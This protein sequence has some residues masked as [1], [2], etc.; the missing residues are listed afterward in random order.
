MDPA[1]QGSREVD[2]PDPPRLPEALRRLGPG[3]LLVNEFFLSIQGESTRAGRPCFFI[4]L[5]GCHIRCS[6][7][8]TPYAFHDGGVVTAEG[9]LERARAAGVP[10]VELTGG[11][12][13]LQKAAP[14]LLER[15]ADAG[16][17]VL[18]ETS[19]TVSIRGVDRRVV[20]IVDVKCP[21]SGMAERNLPGIE[22]DL[23]PGDEL[24]FVI[25]DRP[26]YEWAR[27]WIEG[28]KHRLPA[29]I[30]IHFSPAS[31]RCRPEDLAA[32][33]LE[34]RLPVRLG[35][36]LHRIIWGDRRGV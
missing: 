2:P 15:L 13:L 25:A 28:R 6:W 34:D 4:R 29:G 16:F 21:G 24:K 8:D 23:R 9:C 30:P 7:C 31:G 36:Q 19:G 32:W 26:D 11:E 35:L 10:L 1:I 17:E 18:L 14:V 33:I 12:P 3:E 22:G 5:A 27:E 20:R